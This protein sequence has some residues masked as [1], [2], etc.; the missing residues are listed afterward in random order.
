MI[1]FVKS[2]VLELSV[3]SMQ[4]DPVL[5]ATLVTGNMAPKSGLAPILK[6]EIFFSV[7]NVIISL[8]KNVFFQLTLLIIALTY[9]IF[10]LGKCVFSRQCSERFEISF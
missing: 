9:V 7:K 6:V 1:F 10:E 4:L 8:S 5:G 2:T 3:N